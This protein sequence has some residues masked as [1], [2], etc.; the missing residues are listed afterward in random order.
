MHDKRR[1]VA[2][3]VAAGA[4]GGLAASAAM[5][6]VQ[7]VW[8]ALSDD[9]KH[10]PRPDPQQHKSEPDDEQSATR[11]LARI[12]AAKIANR[13]LTPEQEKAAGG[14]IH[15][16]FGTVAG[17]LY[18]LACAG[19]EKAGIAQ[20]VPFGA[21]VWA[22]GDELAAPKLGLTKPASEFPASK[23][24]YA[25]TAHVLYGYVTETVRRAI[26]GAFSRETPKTGI[27]YQQAA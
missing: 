11:K 27:R 15:Y 19:T 4:I 8:H 26:V 2:V 10:E 17:G 3:N 13:R 7:W 6:G 14:A 21:A 9:G 25:F 18:G 16:V 23:H 1:N 5:V 12:A 20:G 24:A 22:L